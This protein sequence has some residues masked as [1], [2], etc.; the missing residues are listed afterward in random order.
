MLVPV[1][2]AFIFEA[3]NGQWTMSGPDPLLEVII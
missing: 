2:Q 1:I 3:M